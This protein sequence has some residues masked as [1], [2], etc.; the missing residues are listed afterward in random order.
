M[1]VERKPNG[2]AKCCDCEFAWIANPT[3]TY[4]VFASHQENEIER[5]TAELAALKGERDEWE[6]LANEW[7]EDYDKLKNKY[8]PMY[9]VTSKSLR[10]AKE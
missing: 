10:G 8:E 1:L 3:E 4:K 2:R 6:R 9:A 5:L 7:R